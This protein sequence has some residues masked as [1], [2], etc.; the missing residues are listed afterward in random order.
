M[1]I[2]TKPA[3]TEVEIHGNFVDGREIEAGNGAMLDVRNPATGDVCSGAMREPQLASSRRM[4]PKPK[5]V[6][7]RR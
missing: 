6:C 4:S 7:C 3:A 5:S 2:P 1:N